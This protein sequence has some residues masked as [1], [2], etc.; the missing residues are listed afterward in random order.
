VAAGI[1]VIEAGL[2]VVVARRDGILSSGGAFLVVTNMGKRKRK[3]KQQHSPVFPLPSLP[4][5]TMVQGRPQPKKCGPT[6][7]P[8]ISTPAIQPQATSQIDTCPSQVNQKL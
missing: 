1:E 4:K 3:S 8:Q 7:P 2:V 6:F 5:S